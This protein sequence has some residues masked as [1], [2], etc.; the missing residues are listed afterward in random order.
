M[1]LIGAENGSSSNSLVDLSAL[2][3]YRSKLIPKSFS[4]RN[5]KTVSLDFSSSS[6][7]AAGVMGSLR[8]YP[9]FVVLMA[10][11]LSSKFFNL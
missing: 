8:C 1:S 9:A 4:T 2:L 11:V 10:R 5:S 7:T 6:G 3:S